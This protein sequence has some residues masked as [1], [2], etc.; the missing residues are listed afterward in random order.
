[1]IASLAGPDL[2]IVLVVVIVVLMFGSQLP[3]IARNVGTAGREFRKA[4]AEAD[5]ETARERQAQASRAVPE[6]PPA[7]PPA[8]PTSPVSSTPVAGSPATGVSAAPDAGAEPAIS[9]TP[10]QLDALLKAREDQVRRET[11][12]SPDN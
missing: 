10:A 6:A 5:E 1:M 2:V 3:K 11:S 9:L 4:Q 12:S 8:Q 7:I